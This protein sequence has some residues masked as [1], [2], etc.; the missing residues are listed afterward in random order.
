MK[1]FLPF[2]LLI[3]P[4]VVS[5]GELNNRSTTG[6][7]LNSNNPV[8]APATFSSS[9]AEAANSSSDSLTPVTSPNGNVGTN[10]SNQQRGV[11]RDSNGV[12]LP[13]YSN[14]PTSTPSNKRGT[15]VNQGTPS[16]PVQGTAGSGAGMNSGGTRG[17]TTGTSGGASGGAAGGVGG[18]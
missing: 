9:S 6:S 17:G 5:G 14:G 1:R 13:N 18:R 12:P 11:V 15:I 4:A 8:A 16:N 7:R 2:A 3:L 10:P